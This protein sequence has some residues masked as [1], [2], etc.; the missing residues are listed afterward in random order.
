MLNVINGSGSVADSVLAPSSSLSR[1]FDLNSLNT[2]LGCLPAY[3]RVYND[4][5][6]NS[7][8]R[9]TKVSTI[10]DVMNHNHPSRLAASQH[11]S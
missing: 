9:V 8:K 3:L 4:E 7:V 1:Q 11:D 10:C 6:S 5:Q 2:E